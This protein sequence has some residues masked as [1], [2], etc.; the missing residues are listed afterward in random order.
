MQVVMKERR[1]IQA[2]S[3]AWIKEAMGRIEVCT[4]LLDVSRTIS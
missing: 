3:I 1:E 2:G 4:A